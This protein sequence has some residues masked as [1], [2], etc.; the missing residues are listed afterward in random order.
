V[1]VSKTEGAQAKL[2]ELTGACLEEG[3]VSIAGRRRG[4][5]HMEELD[6]VQQ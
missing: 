2:R 3:E 1:G 5:I 6:S 4:K